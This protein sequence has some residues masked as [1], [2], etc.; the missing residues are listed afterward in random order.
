M[1][2]HVVDYLLPTVGKLDPNSPNTDYQH[3]G[4]VECPV[5]GSAGRLDTTEELN[6]FDDAV[7]WE[8]RTL[9]MC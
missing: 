6:N 1:A 5:C 7:W 4:F 9:G 3:G 2:N 8:D